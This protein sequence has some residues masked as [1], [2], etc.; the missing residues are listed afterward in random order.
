MEVKKRC[1]CAYDDKRLL[2]GDG[3]STLAF[4]HHSVEA[5]H[6]REIAPTCNDVVMSYAEM[7]PAEIR[8]Q[9]LREQQQAATIYPK[10]EAIFSDSETHP[11]TPTE[12]NIK[13]ELFSEIEDFGF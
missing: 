1:L 8:R 11:H 10:E 3:H 4:G 2:L 12:L 9:M 7:H 6:V 13:A 5:S